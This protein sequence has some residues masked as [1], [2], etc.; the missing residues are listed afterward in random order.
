MKTT[1]TALTTLALCLAAVPALAETG[2][3]IDHSG[4]LVWAFL[5]L[6]AMIVVAQ[7]VPAVLMV[8]GMIK[9]LVGKTAREVEA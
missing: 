3:R 1:R 6:C 8:M 9:G 5:G 7:V 2:A 4:I